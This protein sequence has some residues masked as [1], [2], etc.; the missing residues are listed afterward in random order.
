MTPSIPG[1]E[2]RMD[3]ARLEAF[4][5]EKMSATRLPGLSIALLKDEQVVYARGFGQRDI[6]RDLPVTPTTLFGAASITKSFIAIAILQ[7][8][9]KGLL[10]LSDPIEKFLPCPLCSKSDEPI[11]IEHL[12]T[13][14]SGTPALGYIEAVLRHAHGIGGCELNIRG[15]QDV[16]NFTAG[17]KGWIEAAPGERWFYLNE[18][19]V[20]LGEIVAKVSGQTYE[21]YLREHVL[22]PLGM[23]RSFFGEA[24]VVRDGE[25][26][27]PYVLPRDGSPP[28]AGRYLYD[29]L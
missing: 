17:G 21:D 5:L 22:G 9:E 18:G 27:L 2:E 13:H 23:S 19:Y 11:R 29:A 28:R 15:V 4:I 8:A 3:T 25:T 7:L 26:A 16:L 14:T 10:K 24:E 12:L 6:A 1:I 20:L